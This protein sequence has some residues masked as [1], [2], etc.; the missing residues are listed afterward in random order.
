MNCRLCHAHDCLPVYVDSLREY[1]R[2]TV[3]DLIFV[4]PAGFVSINEERSRYDL[5]ANEADNEGYRRYLQKTALIVEKVTSPGGRVLD[6]G[7]GRHAVLTSILRGMGFVACAYDPL[8]GI[9]PDALQGLY[10]TIVL[11]ESIEHV[12]DLKKELTTLTGLLAVGGILVIRT[13]LHPGPAAFAGWWYKNDPTHINFFGA[14]T[15]SFM[16]DC[17]GLSPASE[18]CGEIAVFRKQRG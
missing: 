12:R 6:F 3:C 5:H 18:G 15:L 14:R 11:C 8:Y 9:G 7:S 2:C 17:Y 16:A 4:P 1:F 13:G 10:D